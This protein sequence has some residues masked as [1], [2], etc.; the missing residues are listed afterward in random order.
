MWW[1]KREK[2]KFHL[3]LCSTGVGDSIIFVL[4]YL[5]GA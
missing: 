5:T 1:R 4:T 3:G 2:N